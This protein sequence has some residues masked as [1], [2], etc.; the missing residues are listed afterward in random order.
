VDVETN[1][2]LGNVATLVGATV[3]PE[4]LLPPTAGNLKPG[5]TLTVTLIWHAEDTPLTSY[6]VFLHL[7]DPRGRLIAQ[8]DGIPANWSR[9]T[10]GWLRGETIIDT[11]ALTIPPDAPGGDYT[12]STGLYV[13]GGERLTDEDGTDVVTLTT[14]AVQ[15][16]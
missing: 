7:L 16:Q 13:P 11:H 9:P 1:T 6:H 14:V 3:K 15:A 10:T 8:S 5:D 4:I 12:L 2:R